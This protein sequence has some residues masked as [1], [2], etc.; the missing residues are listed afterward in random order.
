MAH[1][2]R[3]R[4]GTAVRRSVLVVLVAVGAVSLSAYGG[5]SVPGLP[6]S[7]KA[8]APLLSS[9]SSAVPGLS[10]TQAM[11]GAG[12][13]LGVAKNGMPAKA[14]SEIE[15]A[16]PGSKSLLDEAVKMGL[17]AGAKGLSGVTD[18]LGK[19]GISPSQLNQLVPVLTNA[20]TGKVSPDV[21]SA[22]ASALK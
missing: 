4:V 9:I 7:V 14:F 12:S 2:M 11:L 5:Q 1:E 22:F 6:K 3:F 8:A 16:I 15:K 10:Q 19:S 13:L 21:A 17:P 20:V 18:F